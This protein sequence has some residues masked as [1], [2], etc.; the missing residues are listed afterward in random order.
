MREFPGNFWTLPGPFGGVGVAFE[1]QIVD[2]S[3]VKQPFGYLS[4]MDLF[5]KDP[6][7]VPDL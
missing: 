7:G 1:L 2:L 4:K 3:E 6:S 5:K